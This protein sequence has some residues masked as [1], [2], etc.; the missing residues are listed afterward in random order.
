M[1][2]LVQHVTGL[3]SHSTEYTRRDPTN[4]ILPSPLSSKYTWGH[5]Q[6]KLLTS[7]LINVTDSLLRAWTRQKQATDIR[8]TYVYTYRVRACSASMCLSVAFV[9]LSMKLARELCMSTAF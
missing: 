5:G 8:M 3:V 6:S 9:F 4:S 1:W 2:S 7:I